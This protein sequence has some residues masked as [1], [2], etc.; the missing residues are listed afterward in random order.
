[1]VKVLNFQLQ[2]QSFQWTFRTDF[3][4]YWWFD[5]LAAQGTLKSLLQHHSSKA[6]VFQHSAFFIVQLS[7]PCM[8]P[9]KTLAL[10]RQTFVSKVMSLLFKTLSKFVTAFIPKS[11][12]LLLSWLHL[13]SAVILKPK[14]IVFHCFHCFPVYLPWSDGT[15]LHDL[16]ILNVEF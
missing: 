10:I 1:M 5:L 3:F 14:K 7:Y 2:H 4:Y 12:R 9:G 8:T 16:N 13:P 11:N 15:G 6:S